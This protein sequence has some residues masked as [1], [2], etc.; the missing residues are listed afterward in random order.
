MQK[1]VDV[2]AH[3]Q[4]KIRLTVSGCWEWT[5][6]VFDS[7]YGAL[8]LCVNGRSKTFRIHRL[9][10]E[11]FVG[12]IPTGLTLDHLCKNK[13]C[14]NPEHLEPVTAKENILRGSSFA[15]VNARKSYCKN[16]HKF[17]FENTQREKSGGRRCRICNLQYQKIKAKQYRLEKKLGASEK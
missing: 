16:G 14:V 4:S 12:P 7:G 5:G 13:I 1:I 8:S 17:T 3:V 6:S 11:I 15:A 9:V 10:Y 2:K